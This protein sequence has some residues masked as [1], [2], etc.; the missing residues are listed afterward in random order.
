MFMRLFQETL[1]HGLALSTAFEF[2]TL[3]NDD[4]DENIFFRGKGNRKELFTTT[5]DVRTVLNIHGHLPPG[6]LMAC[7]T[8]SV[9]GL[10]ATYVLLTNML[11]KMDGRNPRLLRGKSIDGIPCACADDTQAL[12]GAPLLDRACC[13]SSTGQCKNAGKWPSKTTL[14]TRTFSKKNG[15]FVL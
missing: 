11:K 1:S 15:S 5:D 6:P 3:W 8:R 13:E 4:D 7:Q 2:A 14:P 10:K 9:Y 12:V